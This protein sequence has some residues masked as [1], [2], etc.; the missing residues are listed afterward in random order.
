MVVSRFFSVAPDQLPP[1]LDGDPRAY[2]GL[3]M[4]Q[5]MMDLYDRTINAA[6]ALGAKTL[7]FVTTPQVGPSRRGREAMERFFKKVDRKGIQFVW[8]PHGPWE[9]EE[10]EEI[11]QELDLVRS[12]DPLRDPVL[13]GKV[14]Y[15]RLGPFAAMGRSLADDELERIMDHL[16]SFDEAYCFFN[17][18]RAFRDAQRL[19]EMSQM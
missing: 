9:I 19:R 8:E 11:C 15:A 14:A 2:G 17:T 3:Q 4:T 10:I 6:G 7:V 12:I 1:G 18:E 16:D 13:E 5:Q